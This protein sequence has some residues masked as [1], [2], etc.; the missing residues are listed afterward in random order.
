MKPLES[1]VGYPKEQSRNHRSQGGPRCKLIALSIFTGMILASPSF[2]QTAAYNFT[3]KVTSANGNYASVPLGTAVSG[4]LTFTVNG[5]GLSTA[6]PAI[7]TP[8]PGWLL[9]SSVL[10]GVVSGSTLFSS[11]VQGPG[12]SY[13]S[14]PQSSADS[15]A[16]SF[17]GNF[18]SNV[19]Q[20]AEVNGQTSSQVN[21]WPGGP[22][23]NASTNG[24]AP[25]FSSGLPNPACVLPFAYPPTLPQGDYTGGDFN[26]G[27]GV[28]EYVITSFTVAT[29]QVA[30]AYTCQTLDVPG[31]TGTT[32][33]RLNNQGQVAAGT[34]SG[35][36]I[37]S[38]STGSWTQLPAPPA[39]TSYTA[40]NVG[41]EDINDSGTIV[42][43]AGNATVLGQGFILGSLTNP[44][45][46][47]FVPLYT[48]PS[49]TY[50]YSEFRGVG[51]NGLIT[52]F[53]EDASGASIGLIYNPTS[54]SI[55]VFGPGYTPI[56]PTL[57]DGSQSVFTVMGGMNAAGWFALSG[58]SSTH[59][60]QGVLYNPSA[61]ASHPLTIPGGTNHLRGINDLDPNSSANCTSANCI[62]LA[63][64]SNDAGTGAYHLLYVDFDPANGFQTPRTVDCGAALPAGVTTMLFQ[65]INNDNV[66]TGGYVDAAGNSHGLIAYPNVEFPSEI[67]NGAFIFNFPV[68]PNTQVFLD[69]AIASG[70]AY[71]TPAGGPAFQSVT[72]PIGIGSNN[73]YTMIVNGYAFSLPAGKRFDFT[74]TGFPEGVN[75]FTVIGI[76]PGAALSL[77]N[78]HA[79]VTG[80]SFVS[81]GQF[82]GSMLPLTTATQGASG[83][84]TACADLDT[85]KA[86]FGK[87]AGQPGFNPLA[88]TNGDGVVNI[89]DLSFASRFLPAGTVCK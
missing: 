79:F 61:T 69:P 75:A 50:T 49:D 41:A 46:Y 89:L 44:S 40:A 35:G 17:I 56:V 47:R 33:W 78:T 86:S 64:W 45:S 60:A 11:T 8:N 14:N 16:D 59:G 57:S 73:K 26:S 19:M 39:A 66:A 65:G 84:A 25:F 34:N 42:G 70:Y 81:G 30:D 82:T 10:S 43:V 55:G 6:S 80:V 1:N 68:S 62:R 32:L 2:A 67:V 53:A 15:F 18:A 23:C 38:S 48:S 3:G 24:G 52:A 58:V 74:Q 13:S 87:K 83:G 9:S 28:V 20:A 12:I 37:Y 71:A 51:D 21:L 27:L 31:T 54:A 4:T 22:N 36:Y 7:G 76:D 29:P 85:I 5:A 72:L 77:S 88:D 63:G